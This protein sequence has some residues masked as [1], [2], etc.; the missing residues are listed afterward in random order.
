MPTLE[1]DLTASSPANRI[2]GEEK[3]LG[4]G[5]VRYVILENGFFYDKDLVIKNANTGQ[6]LSRFT[7]YVLQGSMKTTK[8]L[9]YPAYF[10]IVIKNP[11][12]SNILVDS[13]AVGSWYSLTTESIANLLGFV[14]GVGSIDWGDIENIPTEFFPMPHMHHARDIDW[15]SVILG[16]DTLTAA[17]EGGNSKSL[18]SLYAYINTMSGNMEMYTDLSNPLWGCYRDKVSG[19]TVNW[20]QLQTDTSS[21]ATTN[22]LGALWRTNFKKAFSGSNPVILTGGSLGKYNSFELADKDSDS[23]DYR[24]KYDTANPSTAVAD[25]S[26]IAIGL[27]SDATPIAPTQHIPLY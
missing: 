19:F 1:L 8:R 23:F 21:E 24:I 3:A 11:E 9:S 27:S 20:G 15:G 25:R 26:Y 22:P 13:R 10:V 16:L 17:I 2:L 5:A 6:T 14:S 4:L 18:Q 7:D 12:V